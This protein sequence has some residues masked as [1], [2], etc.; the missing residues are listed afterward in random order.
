MQYLY[1]AGKE[2]RVI[3]AATFRIA[4]S[5]YFWAEIQ[6]ENIDQLKLTVEVCLFLLITFSAHVQ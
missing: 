2:H 4:S 6:A 1:N 5:Y 3:H